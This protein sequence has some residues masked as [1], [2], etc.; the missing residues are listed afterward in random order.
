MVATTC[1]SCAQTRLHMMKKKIGEFGSAKNEEYVEK[2]Y[3]AMEKEKMWSRFAVDMTK[4]DELDA[5]IKAEREEAV[6]EATEID[7]QEDGGRDPQ[8]GAGGSR[9][10]GMLCVCDLRW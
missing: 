5:R 4:R 7:P 3:E 1:W 8:P 6:E 2:V 10:R 9:N